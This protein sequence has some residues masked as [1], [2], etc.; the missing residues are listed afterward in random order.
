MTLRRELWAAT[1]YKPGLLAAKEL[2]E[3]LYDRT[4]L[5]RYHAPHKD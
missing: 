4:Q 5:E 2:A 1:G 3:Y